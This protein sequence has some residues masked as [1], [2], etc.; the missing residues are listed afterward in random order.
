M[1]PIKI[2]FHSS[3]HSI[4]YIKQWEKYIT[5]D[6]FILLFFISSNYTSIEKFTANLFL[7]QSSLWFSHTVFFNVKLIK[8]ISIFL[9]IMLLCHTFLHVPGNIGVDKNVQPV[10][11]CFNERNAWES[12]GLTFMEWFTDKYNFGKKAKEGRRGVIYLIYKSKEVNEILNLWNYVNLL[13]L[14]SLE[15]VYAHAC[16]CV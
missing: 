3:G 9:I 14:F 1:M 8:K 4:F 15:C 6:S 10:C 11:Q 7:F 2:W 5:R 13:I 12:V 16:V